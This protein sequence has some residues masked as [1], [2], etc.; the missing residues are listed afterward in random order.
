MPGGDGTGP[1]GN[2]PKK[3]NQ[4]VPTPKRGKRNGVGAGLKNGSRKGGGQQGG[5]GRGNR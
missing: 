3:V 2:G 1:D 5:R 4:G